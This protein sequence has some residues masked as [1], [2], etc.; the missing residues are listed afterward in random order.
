MTLEFFNGSVSFMNILI[1]GG[2]RRMNVAKSELE[3]KGYKVGSIGLEKNDSGDIQGAEVVLLP[4]PSTRDGKNI[5]CPQSDKVIP[6]DYI[7]NANNKA[8]ILC[9]GYSFKNKD[10]IDYLNLDDFCLL[11]AVPT[12]EGAI[13]HAICDTPFCLWKSRVLVIGCGRVAKI[14]TH[15]LNAFKCDVTVSARK[16]ADFAYLDA[17]NIKH[18]HTNDVPIKAQNFDI[19]FNTVDAD[20][21]KGN[22]KEL[23]HCYLYDLSTKGC[24]DFDETLAKN[25]NAVKL[26]GI[27]GKTAPIT[28]GKIIAQTVDQLIGEWKCKI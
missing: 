16:P 26:P 3:S 25:L 12:A 8:L 17:L 14:L 18:I 10:C 2:D 23:E 1:I 28:A 22:L 24:I 27:P 5:F 20:I 11:N 15:R 7:N 13:A 6:L 9:C 19:I 21:F 4:V